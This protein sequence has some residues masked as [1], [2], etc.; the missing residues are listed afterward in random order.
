[1]KKEAKLWID[2]AKEDFEDMNYM[3]KERRYRGAVL[4]AQQAVEKIIKGYI[5]ENKGK[6]PRRIHAIEELLKDTDLNIIEIGSP[7]VKELS[8]AY[9]RVRYTDLSIQYYPTKEAVEPPIKNG[10]QFIP[11]GRKKINKEIKQYILRLKKAIDPEKVILFGSFARG[12]ATKWSDIDLLVVAHFSKINF[13]KR[14]DVLYDLHDGLVKDH[15]IHTYG[16]TPREFNSVKE[17]SIL[18]DVKKEG[19]ILYQKHR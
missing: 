9:T 4:F 10:S 12:E 1:M 17:W 3:W 13:D 19:I 2:L 6:T 11:M 18:N 5:V 16:I 7:D 8:K 14:F 15:D